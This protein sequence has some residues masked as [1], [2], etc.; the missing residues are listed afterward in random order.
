[1][2]CGHIFWKWHKLSHFICPLC[3]LV[4]LTLLG[5]T[6]DWVKQGCFWAE[7]MSLK[8]LIL[9]TGWY[10]YVFSI[11]LSRCWQMET[12][13]T[14]AQEAPVKRH[15]Q[16]AK[17]C[18]WI[19]KGWPREMRRWAGYH[20]IHPTA[21]SEALISLACDMRTHLAQGDW[22]RACSCNTFF[23]WVMTMWQ[24]LYSVHWGHYSNPRPSPCSLELR[25]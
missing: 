19:S 1:M 4:R 7:R 23:Y 24:S 12:W 3:C 14:S 16:P 18:E 17:K 5:K 13:K 10:F 11:F 20:P 15:A 21:H 2:Q 6:S 9:Y 25:I 22:E 8:T